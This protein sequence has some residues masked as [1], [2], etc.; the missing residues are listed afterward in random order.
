MDHG[1]KSPQLHTIW[2]N[3]IEIFAVMLIEECARISADCDYTMTNQGTAIAQ[4]FKDNFVI[5]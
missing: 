1:T 2:N 3:Y 4:A 5:K